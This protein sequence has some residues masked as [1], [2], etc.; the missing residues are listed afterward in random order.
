[1]NYS[2][3]CRILFGKCVH[4]VVYAHVFLTNKI[5]STSSKRIHF[6]YFIHVLVSF[7]IFS[8]PYPKISIK[9]YEDGNSMGLIYKIKIDLTII[10]QICVRVIHKMNDVQKT[11]VRVS[12]RCEIYE[13]QMILNLRANKLFQLSAL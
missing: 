12:F 4:K 9:K 10:S 5:V 13:S 2:R 7:S 3:D 11:H 8:I 6:V 1:M